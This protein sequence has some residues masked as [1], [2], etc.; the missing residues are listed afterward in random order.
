MGNIILRYLVYY[1]A[2]I[3]RNVK[4][5][6]SLLFTSQDPFK[7]VPKNIDV[8]APEIGPEGAEM[9]VEY[10]ANGG[11]KFPE[12]KWSLNSGAGVAEHAIKEYILISE[13]PD[14]P[15]P[16]MVGLHG[17]YYAIPPEKTHVHPGDI[18]LD[19]SV[20]A[21]GGGKWLKGGFRLGKNIRGTVYGGAQPPVGHGA[22]RYF[23][24]V[25]ALKDKVDDS[26]MSPVATK[27][28][29]LEEIRGKVVGWGY[30]YGVYENKW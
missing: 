4:G 28:D 27:S 23:Y 29:L 17:V 19:G 9:S 25:I 22:H 26:R 13:D 10:S 24:S 8:V 16:G 21:D 6:D 7:N 18:S 1:L 5:H 2:Q 20:K 14:V 15:I 11:S 30:W 3:L 12:L